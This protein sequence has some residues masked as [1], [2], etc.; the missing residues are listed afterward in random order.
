MR[1]NMKDVLT[2]SFSFF[3]RNRIL[4]L[5]YNDICY[6]D[7]EF[8]ENKSEKL[9]NRILP[10][11]L[12]TRNF[13]FLHGMSGAG[14]TTFLNWFIRNKLD[15]WNHKYFDFE[16]DPGEKNRKNSI[17]IDVFIYDI[18]KMI[19][20]G[21]EEE[22]VSF[23]N[24]LKDHFYF[25]N[26]SLELISLYFFKYIEERTEISE[27]S[28]EIDFKG[29]F[30]FYF[31]LQ[32]KEKPTYD[33][34]SSSIDNDWVKGN[35]KFVFYFD[36]LDTINYEYLNSDFAEQIYW[37]HNDLDDLLSEIEEDVSLIDFRNNYSF[38][39]CLREANYVIAREHIR[40]NY[41][42]LTADIPFNPYDHTEKYLS[43]RIEYAK[44]LESESVR[45]YGSLDVFD[46][47][48]QLSY[49]KRVFIPFLNFDYRKIANFV[50]QI[51][52][53]FADED[54]GITFKTFKELEKNEIY[55]FGAHG[56]LFFRILHRFIHDEGRDI[57]GR[58][59][60]S[61][62]EHRKS[63]AN[64]IRM[65]LIVLM[66]LSEFELSIDKRELHSKKVSL[67]EIISRFSDV[68]PHDD[69]SRLII[70]SLTNA[71][72]CHREGWPHLVTFYHLRIRENDDSK[73]VERHVN[74][75]FAKNGNNAEALE[76][77]KRIELTLNPSGFIFIRFICNHFEFFS[78]RCKNAYSLFYSVKKQEDGVFLF[79]QI[80]DNVFALARDCINHFREYYEETFAGKYS[81][82][83]DYNRSI[84]SFRDSED[85]SSYK[86]NRK[87]NG[88]I[89]PV[90]IITQ[91]IS[92]L[93]AFR[94][95]L[96]K[97]GE[98][99]YGIEHDEL[100]EVNKNIIRRIEK[101]IKLADKNQILLTESNKK[102]V[103]K[104]K[105]RIKEIEESSYKDFSI[106]IDDWRG[107]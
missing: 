4:D 66:N 107:R 3:K 83:N 78:V 13:I 79:C 38:I 63:Y 15:G 41:E 18:K 31:L 40:E 86:V 37:A 36:N 64:P 58:R 68:V 104:F 27:L 92:Y 76:E 29:I 24:F 69:I 39:F 45:S 99:K 77:L 105:S 34:Y 33:K 90:R 1:I 75:Y 6:H 44:K 21:N 84:H 8:Y 47:I 26:K 48:V 25:L 46:Y 91:H 82:V 103:D 62:D 81:D 98:M 71:F 22:F 59:Y 2:G 50:L 72:L 5:Y 16:K 97:K 95:F 100:I 67:F 51:C 23:I 106:G 85:T 42:L 49:I 102:L 7:R 74:S 93:D 55:S 70:K 17:I 94:L 10:E 52:N 43:H 12:S 19:N 65:S 9:I 11:N 73:E 20:S 56:F 57:F 101:Y 28:H 14:K 35:D 80:I 87:K 96:L 88:T 32:I 54:I 30:I 89:H 60:M 61:T 53:D